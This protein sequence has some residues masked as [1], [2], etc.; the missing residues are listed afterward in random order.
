VTTRRKAR[1]EAFKMLFQLDLN[2]EVDL[3]YISPFMERLVS[4]VL[5]YKENIDQLI[6]KYLINWTIDRLSIVDKTLLRIAVYEICFEDDIP[7]AVSIN[8]A[9]ELAH[10]YGDEKSS[11][12]INGILSNLIKKGDT[13]L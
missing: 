10:K 8:E 11:K 2:E 4:G 9:I 1:E 13:K 3:Q 5:K 6:S 12:F 7:Y